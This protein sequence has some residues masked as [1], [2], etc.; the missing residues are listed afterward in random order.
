MHNVTV[1]LAILVGVNYNWWRF[2]PTGNPQCPDRGASIL[3]SYSRAEVR[4]TVRMQL[5]AMHRAGLTSLRIFV[6]HAHPPGPADSAY[7]VSQDGEVSDE[8]RERIGGFVHDIAAA[9]FASLEVVTSFAGTNRI[10]CKRR[11][12][13]DCFD[14]SRTEENWRFIEQTAQTV[15]G[16]RESMNVR[17]DL[18]N[19]GAPSTALRPPILANTRTYLTTIARRFQEEFGPLWLVSAAEDVLRPTV[20]MQRIALLLDDFR[21]AGL[22]PRFLELHEYSEDPKRIRDDL[23]AMQSLSQGL[24]AHF[25]VGEAFYQDAAQA[26][27]ILS[28]SRDHRESRL[29]E[30]MP[31]PAFVPGPCQVHPQP[32][33]T[34]GPYAELGAP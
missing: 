10:Y 17:F 15:L 1:I 5:E 30:V 11:V 12:P 34:P 9:G 13:G 4:D 29:I 8:G 19:E 7:F 25:I 14:P 23:D 21:S 22:S 28:W 3:G 24:G 31:W 18:Q 32:P 27:A 2:D 20:E 6:W 33:Y 16:A 26:G